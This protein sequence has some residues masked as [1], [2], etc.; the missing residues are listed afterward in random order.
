[1]IEVP[2]RTDHRSAA[3]GALERADRGKGLPS[4]RVS[5][6]SA[7]D[8]VK[9][10]AGRKGE[11]GALVVDR[12]V[13]GAPHAGGEDLEIAAVGPE[14]QDA[15]SRQRDGRAVRSLRLVGATGPDGEIKA[16]VHA[17][18]KISGK[19]I[20]GPVAA[21]PAGE[22]EGDPVGG[23]SARVAAILVGGDRGRMIDVK[24]TVKVLQSGDALNPLDVVRRPTAG[25]DA[26]YAPLR[27][28][29]R[30]RVN[31]AHEDAAVGRHADDRG[32]DDRGRGGN[33]FNGPAFGSDGQG[34]IRGRGGNEF[35]G[36]FFG[37]Y[38]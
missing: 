22:G 19:M 11:D 28:P 27:P 31:L 10:M 15:A 2:A 37:S 9:K 1:M 36:P 24:L 33:E 13:G 18:L 20:V 14:P 23:F 8:S 16:A 21:P 29:V 4:P 25:M 32:S 3:A 6:P 7:R 35:Y 34:R 30:L 38:G 17:E 5:V 26:H 12:N